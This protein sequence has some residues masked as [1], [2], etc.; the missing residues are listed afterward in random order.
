MTAREL[1]VGQVGPESEPVLRNLFEHYLHDMSEWFQFDTQPD[2]SY[3]YDTSAIWKKPASAYLVRVNAALAGFALIGSA[4]QWLGAAGA[5]VHDV[6]EFFV[7]RKYRRDGLGREL[8]LRL[9]AERPGPW[10]VRAAE[11]NQPA[12]A[13]WRNTIAG[14]SGGTFSEHE[15]EAN[16]RSWRFFRFDVSRGSPGDVV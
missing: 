9:W 12:V 13:F 8:A 1:T 6:H 15:H 4:E 2:G 5:G 11:G 16:G 10:L 14:Y 7:L 3:S